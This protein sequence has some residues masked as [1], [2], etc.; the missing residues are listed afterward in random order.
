[1]WYDYVPC[2]ELPTA[3][4]MYSCNESRRVFEFG[5]EL[6]LAVS[7]SMSVRVDDPA[8]QANRT[9]LVSAAAN[10]SVTEAQFHQ[11][12]ADMVD[13]AAEAVTVGHF[14]QTVQAHFYCRGAPVGLSWSAVKSSLAEALEVPS[15]RVVFQNNFTD[16]TSEPFDTDRYAVLIDMESDAVS[17]AHCLA[18]R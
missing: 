5:G 8:M 2:D 16:N 13:A 14:S 11:I 15:Y 4:I 6:C 1:M 12:L 7:A 18:T 9:V 10:A 17:E 3:S